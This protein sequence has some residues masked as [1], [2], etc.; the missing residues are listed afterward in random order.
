MPRIRRATQHDSARLDIETGDG[1]SDRAA[2]LL[3]GYLAWSASKPFHSNRPAG[4]SLACGGRHS[5]ITMGHYRI[6]ELDSADHIGNGY[7]VV[8][9]SDTGA[10]A[11]ANKGAESHTAAVEAWESNRRV[12]RLYPRLGRGSPAGSSGRS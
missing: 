5:A 1:P 6:Y 4:G 10:L 2:F 3:G 8:C 12:A 9:R 7:S 11:M